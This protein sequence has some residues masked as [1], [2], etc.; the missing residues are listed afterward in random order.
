[1]FAF[2]SRARRC[3]L[4][5]QSKKKFESDHFTQIDQVTWISLLSLDRLMINELDLLLAVSKC[6]DCEVQRRGLTVNGENR[7]R[8][9]E[10]IKSYVLCAFLRLFDRRDRQT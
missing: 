10:P 8:V 7:Q 2:S 5:R 3:T 1:M 6:V 9:F 4:T